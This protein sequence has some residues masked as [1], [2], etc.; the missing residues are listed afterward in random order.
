MLHQGKRVKPQPPPDAHLLVGG[1]VEPPQPTHRAPLYRAP[2]PR[3]DLGWRRPNDG[4]T[5][6]NQ[7]TLES[8]MNQRLTMNGG[9]SA[10]AAQQQRPITPRWKVE[11]PAPHELRASP[12]RVESFLDRPG[13]FLDE[14]DA[15]HSSYVNA[16]PTGGLTLDFLQRMGGGTSSR[17]DFSSVRRDMEQVHRPGRDRIGLGDAF[18]DVFVSPRYTG[19]HSHR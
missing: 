3:A 6:N 7:A 5:H 19:V 10:L 17:V 9:G 11:M 16:A 8:V 14:I 13:A 15:V 4:A 1:W 2:T 18:A 12:R